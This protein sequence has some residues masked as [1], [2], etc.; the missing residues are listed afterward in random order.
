MDPRLLQK[1]LACHK[2]MDHDH[3]VRLH[4]VIELPGKDETVLVMEL[5]PGLQLFDHIVHHGRLREAEA[6]RLFQQ[7]IAGTDYVHSKGV[8]HRDLKPENILLNGENNVKIADFG[9][10]TLFVPGQLLTESCGSP[11]YAAPELLHRNCSYQGPPVDVWSVGCV[12]Y[13]MLCGELPFDDPHFDQLFRKIRSAKYKCPGYLSIEARH[14]L[15]QIFKVDAAARISIAEIQQHPW[16]RKNLPVE[17]VAQRVDVTSCLARAVSQAPCAGRRASRIRV[18][19]TWPR[20]GQMSGAACSEKP[21]ATRPRPQAVCK[22]PGRRA[23]QGIIAS[24][25]ATWTC[26]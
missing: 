1:E 24:W 11:N 23:Q 25:L 15:S 14:L 19:P 16:F 7:I 12:L 20:G 18:S 22:T 6:R 26:R 2:L 8:V 17:I 5:V 10:S 13:A 21:A 3:V 9:L 4:E